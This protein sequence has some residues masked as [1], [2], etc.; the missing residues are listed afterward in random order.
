MEYLDGVSLRDWMLRWQGPTATGVALAICRQIADAMV[1]VHAKGIIHRDIKP[2]NVILC[3]DEALPFGYRVKLLDFGIAKVPPA[4]DGG[5]V[6]TQVQ[7][8]EPAF[9]GTATYMAPEQ[10]RSAAEVTDR[11]DVYALGVLLFEML[12]G[13]PPFVAAETIEV[14]SMHVQ[15]EPPPL[16]DFAPVVP[17][18]LGAFI[19]SMLAKDPAG[20]PSMFRCRDMLGRP[21]ESERDECPIPGLSPF[22]EAQAELFFGRSTETD[23]L[24]ALLEQART[25]ERRWVQIEGPSGVGG[26]ALLVRYGAKGC[27]RCLFEEDPELRCTIDFASPGQRFARRELGCHGVY[28]PYGDLDARETALGGVR[29]VE[30]VARDAQT[31]AW[32]HSWRGDATGFLAA[33]FRLGSRYEAL[34]HGYDGR[35]E[36]RPGCPACAI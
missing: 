13:R 10:C 27:L 20:R 21:W 2:E 33:R 9:L 11:A 17:A 16:S 35:L 22:I 34:P 18:G 8:A 30:R 29:L 12:A 31:P 4:T 19:A 24:L 32:V 3:P 36:P 23:E 15:S 5:R 7:T 25:G 6:D 28:T 1:E 26:H 14:I